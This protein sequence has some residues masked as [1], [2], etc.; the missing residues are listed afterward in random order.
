MGFSP[1][2]LISLY[3]LVG[4]FLAYRS[5][6]RRRI[7]AHRRQVLGLYFGGIIGAGAFTLLPGRIMNKLVFSYPE[8][9]PTTDRIMFFLAMTLGITLLLAM[10]ST[11][12]A[13]ARMAPKQT[14]TPERI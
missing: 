8:T 13:S 7:A 5:A 11:L 4:S 9:W 14:R 12:A 1:I 10:I 2:H 3:V 6:R